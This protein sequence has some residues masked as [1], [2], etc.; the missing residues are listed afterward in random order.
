[1]MFEASPDLILVTDRKGVFLRVSP[2][3]EVI[4]GYS[5]GEMLGHSGRDFLY[6]ADLDRTRSEMRRARRGRVMRNF[7]SRYVHRDG[8]V[9]TLA[10]TGIWSEAEEKHF[11]IGRDVTEQRT[12]EELF[13][14]AVEACPAGMM[15]IDRGG[16]VVMVNGEIERLFGYHREELLARP[17]DTLTAAQFRGEHAQMRAECAKPQ[18]RGKSGKTREMVA[19]SKDGIEFAI[20]I[21]LTPVW[22]RDGLLYLAVVLDIS[23]RKRADRLKDEFVSTVSHELRTPLTSIAASLALIKGGGLAKAADGGAKLVSIAANNAQRLVRLVNDILDMEKIQS[24]RLVF[25]VSKVDVAAVAALA[26][27][28]NRTLAT[29][30]GLQVR[31]NAEQGELCVKADPD[32]LVQVITNL[33]SNAIK[34]SPRGEEVVVAIGR[35]VDAVR[36]TVRDRGSGIP[37]E[38]RGRIFDRFAQADSSDARQKGGTGLG[39]SIVK[40]IVARLAGDLGFESAVGQGTLFWVDL[41]CWQSGDTLSERS[42][43]E[44]V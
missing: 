13:R 36:I 3:C 33:L 31:L 2:S 39:L 17:L 10:W 29:E 35:R 23:D 21:K 4:L 24:G 41:P 19:V 34:F 8:R 6:P 28:H 27:E 16:R 30:Y 11:F 37:E 44:A 40:E 1:M 26:I 25:E 18:G 14:L 38:F 42:M 32:R 22:I 12:A 43:E 7:E 20:E 15:M 9:V 5:P